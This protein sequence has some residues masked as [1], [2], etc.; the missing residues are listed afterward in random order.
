M[1]KK[2]D[3]S[4]NILESTNTIEE[5]IKWGMPLLCKCEWMCVFVA[6]DSKNWYT[7]I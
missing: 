2:M 4:L 6:M 3:I 7:C 5:L 1:T